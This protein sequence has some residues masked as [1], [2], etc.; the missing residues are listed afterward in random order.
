MTKLIQGAA[1]ISIPAIKHISRKWS[2]KNAELDA[3]GKILEI[4]QIKHIQTD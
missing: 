1:T 3:D 4:R 2:M